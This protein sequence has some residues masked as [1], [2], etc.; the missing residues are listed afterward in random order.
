MIGHKFNLNESTHYLALQGAYK[1]EV[2]RTMSLT[3]L[4]KCRFPA[5]SLRGV[6]SYQKDNSSYGKA[7]LGYRGG[8]IF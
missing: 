5:C 2:E 3:P 6:P 8:H 7:S 1:S 4:H